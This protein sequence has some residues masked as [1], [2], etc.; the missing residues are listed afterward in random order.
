ML[1]TQELVDHAEYLHNA[2]VRS[3]HSANNPISS[4][5]SSISAP[6]RDWVSTAGSQYSRP[7]PKEAVNAV[8]YC[9]RSCHLCFNPAHFLM[10]CPLLGT[11]IRHLA[12]QQRDQKSRDPPAR[13]EFSAHRRSVARPPSSP[14]LADPRNAPVVVNPVMEEVLPIAE[15]PVKPESTSENSVGGA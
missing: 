13:R 5:P 14:L 9:G 8:E 12:Q 7:I 4:F 1:Y 2:E 11:E 15:S 10:D 3:D 6:N